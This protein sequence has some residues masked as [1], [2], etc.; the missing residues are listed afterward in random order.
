MISVM[1]LLIEKTL[2]YFYMK[3]FNIL[4]GSFLT[5]AQSGDI[6]CHKLNRYSPCFDVMIC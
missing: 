3:R 1:K 5:A 4:E 2:K 6:F